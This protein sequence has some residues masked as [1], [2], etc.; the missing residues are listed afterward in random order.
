MCNHI[1]KALYHGLS[2][3]LVLAAVE[4]LDPITKKRYG[5]FLETS[6]QS[7]AVVLMLVESKK[8][9]RVKSEQDPLDTL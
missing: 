5:V 4:K 3:Y 6:I 7:M 9:L 1:S 8:A 2:H